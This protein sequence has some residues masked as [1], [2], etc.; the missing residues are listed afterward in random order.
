MTWKQ[1]FENEYKQLKA[2]H[3]QIKQAIQKDGVKV[4]LRKPEYVGDNPEWTTPAEI[5]A[6]R[7]VGGEDDTIRKVTVNFTDKFF[8]VQNENSDMLDTD[9]DNIETESVE[10]LIKF[11]ERF[12]H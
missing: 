9:Y 6:Y 1:T 8:A 10:E 11:I 4:Y 12:L 2:V 5:E 7:Y 3:K